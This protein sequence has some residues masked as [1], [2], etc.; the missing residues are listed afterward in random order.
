VNPT[1]HPFYRKL[2]LWLGVSCIGF[3]LLQGCVPVATGVI[4]YT[5]AVAEQE[6]SDYTD[7]I[8]ITQQKNRDRAKEGQEPLPILKR[9][10]WLKEIHRP[11]MAYSD[12]VDQY[13]RTNQTAAPVL[14]YEEWK[15]T[16]YPKIL[17]QKKE[18]YE[19]AVSQS[20]L[21]R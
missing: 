11:Q 17:A 10:D 2:Q 9:D 16:E 7:Y 14:S 13:L 8:L 1:I 5:V 18:A 15:G 3:C 12:F 4:T 21:H 6:H 20:N 19:K